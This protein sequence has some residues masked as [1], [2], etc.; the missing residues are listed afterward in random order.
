[1]PEVSESKYLVTMTWDD[2]P[3]LD[4][5]TKAA[6]WESIPPYQREAR[7][8]GIPSLGSGAIYP[9][10]ESDIII[11][12]FEIP[13]YWPKAFGMDVGWK[14]T[15]GV[16]GAY[17]AE[18]DIWYLYSEYY[19]GQAEP[20]IHAEGFRARGEWIPGAI[21][22]ASRGRGQKDGDQL[23]QNYVELGLE[24]HKANNA[25]EAGIMQVWQMLST[26]KLKV[27][28][29]LSKW[30]EEY[31]LYRRDESGKIVKEF[32]HLM[33]TTRYFVMT[34]RQHASTQPHEYYDEED[35]YDDTRD[36]YT[37]Y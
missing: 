17:D 5:P 24:L 37:G 20:V 12:P 23:W 21:D 25:V 14:C 7:A 22:P 32:D 13:E 35:R 31:R 15:A 2:A 34:G 16:W 26:G 30:R 18:S 6:L 8:K 3:H 33:D 19:R 10:A 4:E 1:M 36:S 9:V 27:F 29:T 11:D 28:N